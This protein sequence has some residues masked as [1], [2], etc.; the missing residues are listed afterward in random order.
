MTSRPGCQQDDVPSNISFLGAGA[1]VTPPPCLSSS[2][3]P[4]S[5]MAGPVKETPEKPAEDEEGKQEPVSSSG[6]FCSTDELC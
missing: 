3:A 2:L 1:D 5:T 6:R 4:P